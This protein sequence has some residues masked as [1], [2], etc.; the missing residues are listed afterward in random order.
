MSIFI[1]QVFKEY[2][3]VM[4]SL[5]QCLGHTLEERKSVYVKYPPQTLVDEVSPGGKEPDW[6]PGVCQVT[7]ERLSPRL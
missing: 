7:G 4:Q 3:L 2:K 1:F 5:S 6:R